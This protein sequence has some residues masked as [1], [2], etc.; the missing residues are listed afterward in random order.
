LN[1]V[2]LET[3]TA[4][5]S[6]ALWIDGDVV[7][8][9]ALNRP[10]AHA[11]NLV[12][13]I[14]DALRYGGIAAR[15]LDAVAVSAG[16]GSF[17][18][19][20]I[21]ASTAK[22]LASAVDAELVAVPS[23]EALAYS[24]SEAVG[25]IGTS[26]IIL[27]AFDAR[28]DEVFAAAFRRQPSG[29]L[30]VHR[31]TTAVSLVDLADWLGMVAGTVFLAGDGSAKVQSEWGT[32]MPEVRSL[33]DA[34]VRPSAASVA[35]LGAERLARGETVDVAEFEPFYLKEFVAKLPS[36]SAFARLPF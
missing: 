13:L 14:S 27:A 10:R 4:V 20:R 29:C 12:P 1:L 15:D 2:A 11:E 36:A 32:G 17:T 30:D 28:R 23:L 3:A 19:L 26:D 34:V 9:A 22:G 16:P 6:V 21:G 35:R 24:A 31:E 7:V 5:C 25:A 18:G 8:E 33:S